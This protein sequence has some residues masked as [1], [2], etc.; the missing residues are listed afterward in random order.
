MN[1]QQNL[2][3]MPPPD[4]RRELRAQLDLAK[5]DARK[6][7]REMQEAASELAELVAS[8]W[9]TSPDDV[10]PEFTAAACAYRNARSDN[11]RAEMET[12]LV[13]DALAREISRVEGGAK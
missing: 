9:A 3:G 8:R 4:R 11:L 2:P 1:E 12:G 5:A 13:A 7:A 10:P 6:A